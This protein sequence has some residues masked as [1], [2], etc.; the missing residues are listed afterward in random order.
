MHEEPPTLS[1]ESS[2]FIRDTLLSVFITSGAYGPIS[3]TTDIDKA[4]STNRKKRPIKI[5]Q[6][7]V[8]LRT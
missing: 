5:L 2:P 8:E 3:P 6:R 4:S 1:L 7:R